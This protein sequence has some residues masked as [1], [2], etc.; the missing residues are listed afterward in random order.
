MFPK[1]SKY[2]IINW[3]DGIYFIETVLNE[4]KII[5]FK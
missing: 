5:N 4:N 2:E 1:P 3:I